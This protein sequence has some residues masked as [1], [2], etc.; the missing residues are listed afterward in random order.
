MM[1]GIVLAGGKAMRL[2]D[3]PLLPLKNN[4]PAIFSSIKQ[5]RTWGCGLITII[6]PPSSVI[7]NVVENLFTCDG[8]IEYVIQPEP[9]GVVDAIAR[10][11]QTRLRFDSRVVVAVD[12]VFSGSESLGPVGTAVA[13]VCPCW[14]E[15]Y[16]AKWTGNKWKRR[17]YGN[18]CLTYPFHLRSGDLPPVGY[19]SFRA[20]SDSDDNHDLLGWMNQMGIGAHKMH[21]NNWY[22]IGTAETY[23]Q[24]WRGHVE[25]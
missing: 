1:Q 25:T 18:A 8:R 17:A 9:I 6:V 5:L 11:C 23:L 20:P 22:D 10:A 15:P 12:N 14:M 24:Y 16:L 4:K 3:K 21:W 7:P 2:P 19:E 13:R